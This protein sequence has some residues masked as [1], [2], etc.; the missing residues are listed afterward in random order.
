MSISYCQPRSRLVS[1]KF[2]ADFLDGEKIVAVDSEERITRL[3]TDV[4]C[5]ALGLDAGDFDPVVPRS[6]IS[7][8][9]N[10]DQSFL[11]RTG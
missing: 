9:R 8:K 4:I 10:P 11:W 5:G 3:D 1:K 6:R 7:G 2:G